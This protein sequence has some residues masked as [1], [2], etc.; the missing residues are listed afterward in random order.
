MGL[1]II[2]L[3]MTRCFLATSLNSSLTTPRLI[4]SQQIRVFNMPKLVS[5][6]CPGCHTTTSVAVSLDQYTEYMSSDRRHIQHI[7]L[8][9]Q[10]ICVNGSS[11]ATVVIVGTTC[12]KDTT[13]T[14]E[15]LQETLLTSGYLTLVDI[16]LL[17]N[18]E[19]SAFVAF[20]SCKNRLFTVVDNDGRVLVPQILLDADGKPTA[21]SDA[22]RVL[23]PLGLKGWELWAW[24]AS[25][26]GCLS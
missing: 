23:V 8:T 3:S 13:M 21:V 15:T 2:T 1:G 25:P 22:V 18:G 26:S 4:E 10:T 14:T 5:K 12:L 20:E 19:A 17:R 16:A 11:Q 6:E 24:L 9:C 7:C